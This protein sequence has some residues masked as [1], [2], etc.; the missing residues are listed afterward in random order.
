MSRA[1]RKWDHIQH[2]LST[3]QK[4]LTGFQD[5]AFIHQSLP[6]T[7]LGHTSLATEIG[8]LSMSSPI[9]INA[10][11]GGGGERTYQINRDLAIAARATGIA[12]AVGSQMSAL[13][14]QSE[15]KSYSVVR[16]ENPK[17]LIF[18]NL[19]SEATLEQAKAAVEMVEAN[20]LQ[21]HLNVV[22]ELVMP[23]G[24]RDFTGALRRIEQIIHH[25]KV[26]VIVKEVG[27][28]MSRETIRK[29][30]E[31]GASIVD[32]GGFGGTNFSKIEN[33]RRQRH[34]PFF[35]HWGIPTAVSIS[36][37]TSHKGNLTILASGGIQTSTEAAKAIALGADAVGM[38]GALLKVLVEENL[39]SLIDEIHAL[40]HELKLIMTAVGATS[41]KQLQQAPLILSGDVYHWLQQRGINTCSY[42]QRSIQRS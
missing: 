13:K 36:E 11:T 1:K 38:A 2:A 20:A 21:I 22:Q 23:E 8:E 32:V 12:I 16:K 30:T 10:M 35:N 29:L 41:V 4:S 18:A 6:D 27:F 3:G 5:V 25:I 31:A 39:E 26:P 42:S 19:G 37:A 15:A 33:E 9:F 24:D 7:S 17:G 34:I 14:D 40:H 28:G